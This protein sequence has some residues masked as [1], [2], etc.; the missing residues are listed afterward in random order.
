MVI[1]WQDG[2]HD[3]VAVAAIDVSGLAKRA[4]T[5]ETGLLIRADGRLVLSKHA[6]M[7]ATEM[8]IAKRQLQK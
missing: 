7:Y 1:V 5:G 4:F 6:Q 8:K 3:Y 2:H